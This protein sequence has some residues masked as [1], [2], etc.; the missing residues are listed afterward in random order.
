MNKY[1]LDDFSQYWRHT[2]IRLPKTG[3][4][5]RVLGVNGGMA[6]F[7]NKTVPGGL[8]H[9]KLDDIEWEH[10]K[11][12]TLG[13]RNTVPGGKGLYYFIRKVARVAT[14]GLSD[15]TVRTEMV[16]Y[17]YDALIAL[18]MNAEAYLNDAGVHQVTAEALHRQEYTPFHEAIKLLKTKLDAVGFALS[19]EFAI[20]LGDRADN[21]F[22]LLWK[23]MNVAISPD[24]EKWHILC[25]EY[26]DVIYRQ[27][28]KI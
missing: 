23:Q 10:V 7:E 15:A 18:K 12:P 9:V 27:L 13:Y 1:S 17:V 4:I 28:G 19:P 2:Y 22:T 25:N 8:V 20:V 3:A 21:A 14:K 6:A 5:A 26:K 11:L 16:Q 24:G